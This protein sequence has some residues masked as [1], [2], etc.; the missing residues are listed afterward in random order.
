MRFIYNVVLALFLISA[1]GA[2]GQV[3]VEVITDQD[4]FLP[5][6]T[7]RIGVRIT[8]H[9]GPTLAPG[10]DPN[11]IRILVDARDG[12]FVPIT[13]DRPVGGTFD[14]ESAT[15]VTRR[16]DLSPDFS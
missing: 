4:Q 6:E 15:P 1:P 3:K 11:W 10:N 16:F 13:A 9:S 12:S 5:G 2:L 7:L 8:N 14:V